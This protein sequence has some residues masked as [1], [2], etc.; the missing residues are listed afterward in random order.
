MFE[1]IGSICIAII[2]FMIVINYTDSYKTYK[3]G[4][5]DVICFVLDLILCMFVVVFSCIM[6]WLAGVI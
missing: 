5:Y 4:F 1:I 3:M 6:L 2:M